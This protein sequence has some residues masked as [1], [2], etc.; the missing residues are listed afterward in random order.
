MFSITNILRKTSIFIVF[1]TLLPIFL[2]EGEDFVAGG[3]VHF[4]AEPDE[5]EEAEASDVRVDL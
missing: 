5:D 4:Y 2:Y 3:F 1:F